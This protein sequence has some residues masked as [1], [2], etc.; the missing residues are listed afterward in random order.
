[1]SKSTGITA[2][3]SVNPEAVAKTEAKQAIDEALKSK[4]DEIDSRTDLTDEEKTAAKAEVKDKADAAKSAIDKATKNAEVDQSKST[5]I[6][7]VT[8]VNPEAVAK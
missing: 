8:S 2:V 1:Q 6:T 3:T 7:A 4:T 5:G